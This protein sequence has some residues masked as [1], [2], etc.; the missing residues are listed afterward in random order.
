V[1][2][3]ADL[4]A[5]VAA[6]ERSSE[7]IV[8]GALDAAERLQPALN[9]FSV[10]PVPGVLDAAR[11]ADRAVADGR[12]LGALHGVP[13]AV[14]DLYDVE[15]V[16]TT[17]C[18][19][20][21]D[22][23]PP[24]KRDAPA[25]AALRSA[26]AIVIGKTNMHELAFGATNTISSRGPANNPWDPERTPGGSSG[27]S[28]SA[29]G[30]RIVPLALGSDTGGSVRIPS[31]FC[32][33]SGLKTTHGLFP[34]EGVMPMSPSFDTVGPIASDAID[35]ALAFRVLGGEAAAGRAAGER[36]GRLRRI[37]VP[38]EYFFKAVD[39]E[40]AA[41]VREAIAVLAAREIEV[42]EVGVPWV[43]DADD[44]WITIALVEFAR[45]YPD[46]IEDPRGVDPGIH[47]LMAAGGAI[48]AEDEGRA[49]E[50]MEEVRSA[51]ARTFDD[52]DVL[53]V[54][55]T[56]VVA[57]RHADEFVDAGG[58]ELPVHL[59]GPSTLTRMFNTPGAPAIALPCGLS[60]SGLPIGL[61]IA[62]PRE[63][64]SLLLAAG[65]FF[66]ELTDWH[67]L[68]PPLHA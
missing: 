23:S 35:L 20:A 66:Q 44:A 43:S 22:A 12:S 34:L 59:G 33:A 10:L 65:A 37:G 67:T 58:V 54:P 47:G 57:P 56:P 68:L 27:G 1:G 48:S 28:A 60:R 38:D 19:A 26:G 36:P 3:L 41:A 24:A 14:K 52:V 51:Y 49:R 46:L 63:S 61:Q 45:A 17:G 2:A 11:A 7:E 53:I 5:A 50:R 40:V 32:G 4:A 64:E 62:G 21:Y 15:G 6:R 9:A 25:V 31:S 8:R 18:C 39:P 55:A 42:R 13:V 29:V 16:V 30:A